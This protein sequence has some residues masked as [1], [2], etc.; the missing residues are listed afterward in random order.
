MYYFSSFATFIR[1]YS[2][3]GTQISLWC[4]QSL[5][6]NTPA[7]RNL[8]RGLLWG[9]YVLQLVYL[10]KQAELGYFCYMV[11]K[12]FRSFTDEGIVR[13]YEMVGNVGHISI[14]LPFFIPTLKP[15]FC[16]QYSKLSANCM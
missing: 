2:Y 10:E 9:F 5:F 3:L 11:L 1:L 14:S 7:S 8:P 4:V 13:S 16:T 6:C 12:N 15:C